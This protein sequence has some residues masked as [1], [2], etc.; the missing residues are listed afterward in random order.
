M[1]LVHHFKTNFMKFVKILTLISFLTINFLFVK[2]QSP[3]YKKEWKQIEAF[4]KK[5]LP[6]SALEVALK[7]FN[8][9]VAKSNTSQQIKAAMY[10]MRYRNMV[11]QD[12]NENN[13][14]YLDT[15]IAKTKAPAK[16]ILQSMQ[17]QMFWNYFQNNR[18][19]FY[20]R[21]KLAEEKSKDIATW[22]LDKIQSTTR[23]LYLQ[24]LANEALLKKTNVSDYYAIIEKGENTEELRPTLYDFL[25][26]RALDYFTNT[27]GDVTQPAY[28]FILNDEKLFAP[29]GEFVKYAF[30]TKDKESSY[31]HAVLLMQDLLKFHLND[32]KP[33]ALIDANL[34]RLDFINE[35]GVFTDKQKM[36]E[37]AL[38][39][40]EK[41]N[42]GSVAIAEAM[43]LRAQLYREQGE[44]SDKKPSD[45]IKM[46]KE[47]FDAVV[48]K[49]PKSAAA[50]K[51]KNAL[52]EITKPSYS[53]Q[54]EMVNLP[55]MPF[56]NL[57]K[58]TNV[59]KLYFRIIKTDHATMRKNNVLENDNRSGLWKSLLEMPV[60]RNW[61][62][63]L[64]AQ[65]DYCEHSVETKIEKLPTG[66]YYIIT[67]LKPDF[68]LK[69]NLLSRQVIY[70]SNIS[71]IHNY[72]GELFALHR[73][74]G[75]PMDA[76]KVQV[77]RSE[78]DYGSRKYVENKGALLSTDKNGFAQL[79]VS[80]QNNYNQILQINWQGDELF[81]DQQIS[82]YYYGDEEHN[83]ISHTQTF[84]FTDRSIYR[85]GQK[86]FFKGI[87]VNTDANG[88]NSKVVERYKTT[89]TLYD[90]NRQKQGTADVLTNQYGS[91]NGSFTLPEGQM[92]GQFSL[93]DET[94]KSSQYFNVEEYKRP[95]FA[96]EIKKPE[97]IYKV[98]DSI[99]VAGNAKAYAGNNIDGAAVKYRVVR[100]VQ[101]P[102]W[103]WGWGRFP[104][105][106]GQEM[107]ITNGETTTDANGDFKIKFKAIPDEAVDKKNQPIFIYEVSADVT[108]INGETRSGNT[109]VR[110]SYQALQLNIV[111]DEKLS[112]DSISTVKIRST[113]INDLHQK[114][115]VQLKV[116]ALKAPN[117]IYRNR[118]WDA[119]DSFIMTKDEHDK[120]FPNDAYKDEDEMKNW[121]VGDVVI[122]V[123]DTTSANGKFN[124]P[125]KKLAAGWYKIVVIDANDKDGAHA[126][127]FVLLNAP[128]AFVTD[129]PLVVDKSAETS[130]P[131]DKLSYNLITGF[132]RIWLINTIGRT[133][134]KTVNTFAE[135]LAGRPFG[136]MIDIAEDDRGG[137]GLNY[138]FVKNNRVYQGNETFAV[139][140]TNKELNIS[141]ET[142]RDKTLPGSEEKWTVKISG[143]KAEKVAAE[144]LVS[145]YDASLD[146]FKP[147]SWQDFSRLWPEYATNME[148]QDVT[149]KDVESEEENYLPENNLEEKGKSYDELA[150]N[151]WSEGGYGGRLYF[152]RY[153]SE[154][155]MAV[156]A[157]AAPA[158][159]VQ[160]VQF[161]PPKIVK[162]EE[163]DYRKVPIYDSV[164][165]STGY[166]KL[167]FSVNTPPPAP[168]GG[169]TL[170]KNFNETAFFFPDLKTDENGNVK[171]SFTM[172]E[173]LTKWKTMM[174]A[175]T[176]ELKSA[177]TEKTTITQ[178]ELMVQPNPTRF[179]REG[180][181]MEFSAKVVNMSDKE[182]TGTARLELLDASTNKPVDGWFKNVF[183]T[184]YFTVAAGQSAV[185][186]F[187][188]SIPY[189]FGSALT[190]RIVASTN[191]A[192]YTD[193]EEASQPVLTNR[194]LVTETL[195]L[196]LRNTDSKTFSFDKLLNSASSGSL[197]HQ[198][199]TVE[200]TTNPA[201]YAV[202]A[203]PYLM[204]YPY[205]CAEQTFNRYYANTLAA[206]V[207]NSYPKIKAVLEKWKNVDTAALM[208]NLQKNEELKSALLQETPWV[209]EAQNEAQQKRNIALLFDMVR[210]SKEGDKSL[211]KLKEMQSPNG[212]FVWF[213]G[214]PDDRYIT[215]YILAG[216]GHLRKLNAV[217]ATE[218]AK[219]KP[220][221]DKAVP[222]LDARIKEDYDRLLKSKV[223]LTQN[224]L[225]YI[226]AHYLYTR[227]FFKEYA[228]AADA[229]KAVDYY[230]GQAKKYWLSNGRYVQAML[231]LALHRND[232]VATPKAIIKS[233]KENSITNEEMGMYWKEFGVGGYF[234]HQALIESHAMMIEAFTDIDK[235]EATVNDLKT[236][237][238]K[239][240]QVQNWKTTKATAEA[241][242]ALLLNGSN[243]L[244]TEQTVVVQLGSSKFSSDNKEQAGTGYFKE[245][246]EGAK[247]QPSMGNIAVSLIQPANQTVKQSPKPPVWGAVYWQYFEDLDKI[248]PAQTPLKLVKKLFVEKNSDRG[249][250]LEA[251]PDG[252]E[253]HIGD[254]VKVRIELR[255]DRDME[256]V[257]MKDMRAAAME[258]VNVLSEYKWQDGLGYYESTKDA[259]TNF[260][261]SWLP[262][263]TY[264][265]E[266][267]MFV[268]HSGNFS[269]GIT[270]I[271]CMYAP[272]FSAHSEGLRVRVAEK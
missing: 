253:L 12:N 197:T 15:L 7:I 252:S 193:G 209:L 34:R 261:F 69:D 233:L 183:P 144:A 110:V 90:A 182:M 138:V 112:T 157:N 83:K 169:P 30:T 66:A 266:Y 27:E 148:W 267:P 85:P 52:T 11:E 40:I 221:V 235:N 141:F 269:N 208:S 140:W 213:K 143:D 155:T 247:V 78:Y 96:T 84:I 118:Y 2:A 196:N 54:T 214:G 5:G 188:M 129:A 160:T 41:A 128:N 87:V 262:R 226:S 44:G 117:K 60:L 255:V 237:L 173:A 186:K 192:K 246:I 105:W 159:E 204:E 97:G 223:K 164:G 127:K 18:W 89:I 172:P 119:P 26:H 55:D 271:Q 222:Y 111:S 158:P 70:V 131:G 263:G 191:D 19:R 229:K 195:P 207:A 215:Q 28:K 145:M 79:P 100:K 57:V 104:S 260:F 65:T 14:F 106:D 199:L 76:A 88:R 45:K 194:M 24:S 170:R 201:W 23:K 64:P 156:M 187:P 203:L 116:Y 3:D 198:S 205:E 134:Q 13:V 176:P 47:L 120:N 220:I 108:D 154:G 126:E 29:A 53:I 51:A 228:I 190:Y 240:K 272:E 48:A 107:E 142:F 99:T 146:Q 20:D 35:H 168:E 225:W 206:Y 210:L 167:S 231:A 74:T 77:W 1:Y 179:V 56:K 98:N 8:D 38:L 68:S 256:Y 101:Y 114:A 189:G 181:D 92:N 217:S 177:Y 149:F 152:A 254:K 216:I 62:V 137:L 36:Y 270:T 178:K 174:L 25:A 42:P 245:K 224:N 16:N 63:T 103:F 264:V 251:V 6:K 259:S 147:H 22:S 248:T 109:E 32:E 81:T 175:H 59:E 31:Y 211:A 239:Q 162:D 43:Y 234:W 161:T 135:V 67:S 82:A 121:P 257:H 49:F 125:N 139:P 9:A 46:A 91:F 58:Y 94:T 33:D 171:F 75:L 113:N 243:W 17:A 86:I 218:Y 132:D 123:K 122:D 212:G 37:Q 80:R 10:Q 184:Q 115:T 151:G 180:D 165:F 124:I 102:I 95:K 166:T 163:V 4:D 265:F 133:G 232:D 200:F 73:N 72:K 236:W 230:T 93:F 238:L 244:A 21:T 258:P 130:Q 50:I 150:Q 71:Y 202:Q 185:V 250:I 153:K 242:Y 136:K 39:D 61:D 227:S 268:T 219:L 241:C 249:P